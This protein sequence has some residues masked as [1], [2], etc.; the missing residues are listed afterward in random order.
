VGR[1]KTAIKSKSIFSV[2]HMTR[3]DQVLID[4]KKIAEG[5]KK[6]QENAVPVILVVLVFVVGILVFVFW[7]QYKRQHRFPADAKARG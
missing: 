3:G 6:E 2:Y 5:K 7:R 4:Y 1:W